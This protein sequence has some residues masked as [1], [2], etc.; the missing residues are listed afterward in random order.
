MPC[1]T[2]LCGSFHFSPHD[3]RT[4]PKKSFHAEKPQ[5]HLIVYLLL[6]GWIRTAPVSSWTLLQTDSLDSM[7]T[8]LRMIWPPYLLTFSTLHAGAFFGMTMCAG[9]P[10][11]F[12]AK[13]TAA[14]W[15][16]LRKN[17]CIN[18]FPFFRVQMSEKNCKQNTE[19]RTKPAMRHHTL[20]CLLIIKHKYRIRSASDLECTTAQ[21]TTYKQ[22]LQYR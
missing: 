5:T 21:V 7:L 1:R 17:R 12:A 9:M 18:N 2:G 14:A 15:F 16:P 19:A 6:K 10:R 20:W 4:K 13:A 8:S 11:S 22:P 3:R